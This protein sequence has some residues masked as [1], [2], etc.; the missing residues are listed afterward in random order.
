MR[1]IY[2]N[3]G[4]RATLTA[5]STAGTLV[6]ANMQ[7]DNKGSVWRSTSTSATLTLT[8][9][10]AELLGGLALAFC[11]LSSTA[12]LRERGY[13]N[14]AD[15]V[16]VVDTGAVHAAAY[17]PL[18]MWDWGIPLGVNAYTYGGGTYGRAWFSKTTVRKL[19]IDIVDTANTAGYIEVSRLVAGDYWEPDNDADR[20]MVVTPQDT[21]EQYRTQ[22]GTLCFE[23]GVRFRQVDVPLSNMTPLDRSN[24]WR[25]VRGNGKTR[26]MFV[27]VFPESDD[28]EMEQAYQV[29]GALTDMPSISSPYYQ[30]YAASLPV[31]EI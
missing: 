27:S 25:I 29:Y 10:T 22:G 1:I 11:N 13:T 4:D 20:A 2:D 28:P 24:F 6:A 14:A 19:V 5:S 8:W 7:K 9:P 31:V 12:T 26:P 17:A 21:S 15:T 30:Q 18:G 16:P 23:T 3:A